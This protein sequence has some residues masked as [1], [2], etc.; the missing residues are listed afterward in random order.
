MTTDDDVLFC[1]RSFFR[2]SPLFQLQLQDSPSQWPLGLRSYNRMCNYVCQSTDVARN[3]GYRIGTEI[4]SDQPA[5]CKIRTDLERA[6]AAAQVSKKTRLLL[7]QRSRLALLESEHV[8]HA[9]SP[10]PTSL[11]GKKERQA[12]RLVQLQRIPSIE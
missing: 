4:L 5:S 9:C 6:A 2:T 12:L 10:L 3:K 11:Q 8:L 7:L 1:C